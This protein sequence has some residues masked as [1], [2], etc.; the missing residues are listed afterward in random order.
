MENEI[1]NIEKQVFEL[2]TIKEIFEKRFFSIPD[3]QR[4]YAW[5]DKQINDLIKDIENLY[6][7]EHKHYTGTIVA[8]KVDNENFD[9]VDGQQRITTLII[10][11]SLL[12]HRNKS[13]SLYNQ[14]LK[15][16]EIG[17][18]RVV[19][20]PNSETYDV[21]LKSIIENEN[22]SLVELK[23]QANILNAKEILQKWLKKRENRIDEIL[24]IV[25]NKLGFIFFQPQNN[26]EIGI[27]FEVINNRGKD[28]SELEKIK[29][30]FI[31]YSSVYDLSELREIINREWIEIGRAHV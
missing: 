17:N 29:N 27:M 8:S 11:L 12:Y 16:G 5:E 1:I 22:F 14:Y 31:Y 2:I 10:I 13:K 23:S 21:F 15:R 6:N 19:L 26:K 30:Y 3:Y 4:G 9:I 28:L 24:E 25:E 20:K 18:E 7:N